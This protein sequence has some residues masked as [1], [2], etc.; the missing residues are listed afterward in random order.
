MTK[1]NNNF[2]DSQKQMFVDQ[3][4][5]TPIIQAVCEKTGVSRATFYRWRKKDDK[6][7]EEIEKALSEGKELVNDLAESELMK[8]IRERNIT[9][10]IFWLKNH[11]KDYAPKLQ[12]SGKIKTEA[13]NLTPEQEELIKKALK[14]CSLV[15][16]SDITNNK[17]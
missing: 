2:K 15:D 14:L 5:K 1:Q 17:I 12:I 11:H 10:I 6:F 16:E 4:K 9:S 3:L 13:E 7:A 8:A